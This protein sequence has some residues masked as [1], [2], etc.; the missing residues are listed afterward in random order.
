MSPHFCFLQLL[1]CHCLFLKAR[2]PDCSLHAWFPADLNNAV[3][4]AAFTQYILCP[5]EKLQKVSINFVISA[6]PLQSSSQ[7]SRVPRWR[8]KLAQLTHALGRSSATLE[9]G[10]MNYL[11]LLTFRDPIRPSCVGFKELCCGVPGKISFRTPNVA[12]FSRSLTL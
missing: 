11:P 5:W 6:C 8:V 1:S 2:N 4:T 7:I 12:G 10:K 9:A 3:D